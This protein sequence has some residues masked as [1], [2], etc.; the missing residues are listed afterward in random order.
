MKIPTFS[1]PD[2]MDVCNRNYFFSMY[3]F[4]A[5]DI[6]F[7]F[8][9]GS[10]FIF[11]QLL[12]HL[13]LGVHFDARIVCGIVLFPFLIGNLHLKYNKKKTPVNRQ[14]CTIADYYPGDG[15]ADHLYEK[16]ACSH[17]IIDLYGYIICTNTCL[18]F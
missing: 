10:I 18:A 8:Q 7:T 16:R 1:T 11:K 14:Y 17:F 2:Q 12:T 9:A 13:L 3:G 5:P 15:A 6:F 4:D